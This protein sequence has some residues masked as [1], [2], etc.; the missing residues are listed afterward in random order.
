MK[1]DFDSLEDLF[2]SGTEFPAYADQELTKRN[3]LILIQFGG[4]ERNQASTKAQQD[5]AVSSIV[6]PSRRESGEQRGAMKRHAECP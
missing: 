4:S 1:E 2:Q 5:K 6:G 3:T